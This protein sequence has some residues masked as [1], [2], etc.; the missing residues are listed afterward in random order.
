M[1]ALE[2]ITT[3]Q[4]SNIPPCIVQSINVLVEQAKGQHSQIEQLKS[5]FTEL[6]LKFSVKSARQEATLED[7]NTA[8]KGLNANTYKDSID[9]K[10]SN[11]E[12]KEYTDNK[13]RI[14]NEILHEAKNRITVMNTDFR[15]ET[16]EFNNKIEKAKNEMNNVYSENL[17][18]SKKIIEDSIEKVS[19]KFAVFSLETNKNMEERFE[20]IVEV[21][22]KVGN[23]DEKLEKF[24]L[25]AKASQI[26]SA[27]TSEEVAKLQKKYKQQEIVIENISKA[28]EEFSQPVSNGS[29]TPIIDRS[30]R[31]SIFIN[32]YTE[33]ISQI[34][35]KIEEIA[36][37]HKISAKDLAFQSNNNL[38]KLQSEIQ[39][40]TKQEIENHIEEQIFPMKKKLDWIPKDGEKMRNMS[41]TEARLFLLESRIR[42]EEKARII[43]DQKLENDLAGVKKVNSDNGKIKLNRTYLTPADETKK[44]LEKIKKS[45]Q[46]RPNS[47]AAYRET[48][49][50]NGGLREKFMIRHIDT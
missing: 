3:G 43:F 41:V 23:L 33:K 31:Q 37:L 6:S 2:S 24:E 25:E 15:K 21:E 46:K 50:L 8:F 47:S 27:K 20:K 5:Q 44:K 36:N 42:E 4:W 28:F 39:S 17:Q 9:F 12:L 1:Q 29:E 19:N 14:V 10:N 22:G 11:T 38:L 34:E 13:L 16:R 32:P 40:W 18:L 35:S 49:F 30:P 26:S 7:L 48:A 45:R